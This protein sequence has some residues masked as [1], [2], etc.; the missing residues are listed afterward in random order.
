[1]AG[2]RRESEDESVPF[3]CWC[4]VCGIWQ[5]IK[6]NGKVYRSGST[7]MGRRGGGESESGV[8]VCVYVCE[9]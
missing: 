9:R 4:A 6:R 1:M 3:S 7:G 8:C 5:G 2:R